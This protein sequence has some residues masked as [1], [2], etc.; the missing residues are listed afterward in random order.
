MTHP[1]AKHC[2]LQA[3]YDALVQQGTLQHDEAQAAVLQQLTPFIAKMQTYL[4]P[5]GWQKIW[6]LKQK[7]PR[8]AYLFG[9]VGR[10]KTMLMDL[11]YE[12]CA[13]KRVLRTHFHRFMLDMHEALN[14]KK[15]R[16]Q[17][18]PMRKVADGLAAKYRLICLDELQILDIA[19]AMIVGRVFQRLIEAGVVIFTTSNR[20]PKELYKDGLQRERF[21]PFIAL[22]EQHCQV[23]NLDAQHDYR[24]QHMQHLR[25]TYLVADGQEAEE[26]LADSFAE[27]THNSAPLPTRLTVQGRNL[28]LPRTHT[29]VAWC[30]FKEL[31]ATPLGAADYA[32]IATNFSTLLLQDIPVL[33]EETR[34]EAKRFVT[35]IDEL[36]NHHTNLICTA[37]AAPDALYIKGTG[38]FEF[39]R[40]ASRLTEMQSESYIAHRHI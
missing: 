13:R 2:P 34:N 5:T 31:C 28:L 3:R 10:G 18:H 36:Y 20:H 23:I 24:L 15:M 22:I 12:T 27:L 19:D 33:T 26:F 21:L 11:V 29:D 14:S 30:S 38:S 7:P 1:T 40:T 37:A 17:K 9:D 39:A 16:K 32:E 8:G 35:L 4:R 25:T 6:P